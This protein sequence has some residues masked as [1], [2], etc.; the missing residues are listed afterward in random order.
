MPTSLGC[1]RIMSTDTALST[2]LEYCKCPTILNITRSEKKAFGFNSI[3]F[4]V[5]GSQKYM[6]YMVIIRFK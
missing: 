1:V 6:S 5:K 4:I 2:S 3:F